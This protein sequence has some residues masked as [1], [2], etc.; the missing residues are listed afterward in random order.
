MR[1]TYRPLWTALTFLLL[2]TLV[3]AYAPIA[4]AQEPTPTPENRGF[5]G[6]DSPDQGET[7]APAP[8]GLKVTS[9]TASSVSLSW[10]SVRGA[11]YYR[12]ERRKGATGTWTTV[13][14]YIS[15]T[16]RTVS[17]L[18]CNSIYY[19]RVSA[20]GGRLAVLDDVWEKRPRTY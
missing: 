18:T 13:S 11:N 12:L 7:Y 5:G 2:A 15:G 10:G 14:S 6:Q 1:A 20:R 17:L 16:S 4:S 19:F 8:S 9:S 3:V